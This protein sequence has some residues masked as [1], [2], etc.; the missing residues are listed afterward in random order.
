MRG[1]NRITRSELAF[2][3]SEIFKGFDRQELEEV[4]DKNVPAETLNFFRTYAPYPENLDLGAMGRDRAP[5]L[6]LL[7][8]LLRVLEERLV[9]SEEFDS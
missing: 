2:E 9:E 3:F 7:G 5:N 1:D 4:I 6:M 8:Y